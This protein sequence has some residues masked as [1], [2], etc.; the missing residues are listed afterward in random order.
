MP[1]TSPLPGLAVAPSADPTRAGTRAPAPWFV[2]AFI[3]T[4]ALNSVVDVPT[5]A[6]AAIGLATTTLLTVGLAALGVQ[7]DIHAIRSRGIRP[8]ILALSAFL[9]IAGFS[10]LLVKLAL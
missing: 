4:A 6:K 10:L 2:I 8:L 3:G 9:I 1:S 5:E 7:A